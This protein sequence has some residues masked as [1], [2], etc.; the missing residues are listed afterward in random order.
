MVATNTTNNLF[1]W[2]STIGGFA[3][4]IWLFAGKRW[5]SDRRS[6]LQIVNSLLDARAAR[7]DAQLKVAEESR[8]EAKLAHEESQ[9]QIEHAHQEAA[10]I[11]ARAEG[12][13]ASLHQEMVNDAEHEKNRI[14]EQAREEIGAERNRAILTLRSRAADVAVDA[15]R[16][17]LRRTIDDDTDHQIITRALAE[18]S[19]N[20]GGTSA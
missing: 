14:I 6:I 19:P 9:A 18:D 20:G 4:L 17:V 16:E 8:V 1:L 2:L 15:A 3:V 10:T 7:I 5:G 13:L 12:M 11:V